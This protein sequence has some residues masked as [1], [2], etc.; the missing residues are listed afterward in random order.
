MPKL[1][2]R[3]AN[4]AYFARFVALGESSFGN[5]KLSI[6]RWMSE[7][8]GKPLVA[9]G[10]RVLDFDVD[11][12]ILTAKRHA[13]GQVPMNGTEKHSCWQTKC[14]ICK[15]IVRNQTASKHPS[16]GLSQRIRVP[17]LRP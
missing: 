1:G 11:V 10:F 9:I 14:L 8:Q 17:G 6:A 2:L 4:C 5:K 13:Q 3:S 12:V 7:V 15:E 16:R